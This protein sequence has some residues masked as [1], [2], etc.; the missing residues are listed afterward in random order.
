[1]PR[2]K[3]F[4]RVIKLDS[5]RYVLPCRASDG[6]GVLDARDVDGTTGGDFAEEDVWT[7]HVASESQSPGG[8][9]KGRDG[10][11]AGAGGDVDGAVDG[12]VLPG[13]DGCGR[14]EAGDSA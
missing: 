10:D 14:A 1:M 2:T 13:R 11:V 3:R 8:G 6:V 12:E 7:T 5:G 4:G 9:G